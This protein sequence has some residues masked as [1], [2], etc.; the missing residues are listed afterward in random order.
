MSK[1]VEYS[2]EEGTKGHSL[3]IKNAIVIEKVFNA[4]IKRVWKAITDKDEM[5]EW[6]FEISEFKPE[7]G[8]EFQFIGGTE[9]KQFLHL[10]KITDVITGKKLAYSWRYDGYEGNSEV[11]FELYEE[12]DKTRLRLTH[13]GLET[14][15]KGI[16]DFASE[17][18][19]EGWTHIIDVALKEFLENERE[20]GTS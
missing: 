1:K 17:N 3:T 5:K 12:T 9:E 16:T 7:I 13:Q 19:V 10:C 11:L 15:P 6:Y 18:F 14:F 8:F 4:P 2:L 20:E